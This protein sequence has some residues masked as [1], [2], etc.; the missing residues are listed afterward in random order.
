V[1]EAASPRGAQ[2]IIRALSVLRA[3][4]AERTALSVTE[5]AGIIGVSV[6]TA[7][8]IATTLESQHYLSR[9]PATKAFS[10]G[11]ELL[12]LA[13]L[14]A[15]SQD[16]G[17]D[18]QSLAAIRDATGET[19]SVHVRV[20]D[21][22]VCVAEEVSRQ[23]HRVTSGVGQS[24]PLNAGAA[25]KI[26]LSL[27]RDDEVERLIALTSDADTRP[28]PGRQIIAA[29]REARE[30]G[31]AISQGETVPGAIAVA[32]AV[33]WNGSGPPSAVNLVGP[34][35]RM[36]AQ[37]IERGLDEIRSVLKPP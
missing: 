37:A 31:Y 32:V 33:P 9:D 35:D 22:R 29:I 3:F 25:G 23:P 30:R 2:A 13:R 24:Y 4:S 19:C 21:R 1:D 20:G 14:V 7:H 16:S 28:L 12:G 17:I 11:P 26:I 36:T 8:R 5:I 18:P 27:L 34:R 10:L 6:P 15:D